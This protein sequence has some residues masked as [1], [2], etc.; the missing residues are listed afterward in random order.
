MKT[1]KGS[2][3]I[4]RYETIGTVVSVDPE[5]SRIVL[6]HGE[7]KDFMAPM[8]MSYVVTPATLLRGL[9]K[10]DKVRFTIDTDKRTIVGIVPVGK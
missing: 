5:K 1:A 6:D 10:G 4:D 2:A 8:V 3:A 9:A 7:I